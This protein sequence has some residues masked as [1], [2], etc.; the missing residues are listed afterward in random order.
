VAETAT[1]NVWMVKDGEFFTPIANGTFLAGL[2]RR[3]HMQNLRAAGYSVTE[4]VLTLD[5]FRAA[6]EVFLTGNFAKVTPVAQFDDVAYGA[7]PLTRKA[8]EIYM[9]WALSSPL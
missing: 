1:A 5:D 9:D 6:D 4:A 3:R 7:R 8:R 2:T